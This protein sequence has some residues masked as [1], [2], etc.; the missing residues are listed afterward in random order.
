MH[1]GSILITVA[2][3]SDFILGSPLTHTRDQFPTCPNRVSFDYIL[4]HLKIPLVL[5]TPQHKDYY[6]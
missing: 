1:A 3:S 2:V 5:L 4:I 6:L